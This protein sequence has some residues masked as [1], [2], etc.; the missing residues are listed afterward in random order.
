MQAS[1]AYKPGLTG[2]VHWSLNTS[3]RL[4]PEKADWLSPILATFVFLYAVT[5][6]PLHFHPSNAHAHTQTQT[7]T[8]LSDVCVS[9]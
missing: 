2:A 7:S 9:L 5:A 4:K 8:E 1:F 6:L 3:K